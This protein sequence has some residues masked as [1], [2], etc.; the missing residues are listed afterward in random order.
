MIFC[1]VFAV[2]IV[3]GNTARKGLGRIKADKKANYFP[4]ENSSEALKSGKT[5]EMHT[6]SSAA[7]EKPLRSDIHTPPSLK[8]NT[9]KKPLLHHHHSSTSFNVIV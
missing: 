5:A 1:Q 4:H 7:L 9:N 2:M 3:S 8:P 6:S